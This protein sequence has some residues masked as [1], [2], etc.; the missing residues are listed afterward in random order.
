M[1][2]SQC[3]YM[4]VSAGL[5]LDVRDNSP[6]KNP[7]FNSLKISCFLLVNTHDYAN[8]IVTVASRGKQGTQCALNTCSH[9]GIQIATGLCLIFHSTIIYKG[10]N[11]KMLKFIKHAIKFLHCRQW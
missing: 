7:L 4:R 5:C 10:D 11:K 8:D 1:K 2:D 3:V 6:F 9:K